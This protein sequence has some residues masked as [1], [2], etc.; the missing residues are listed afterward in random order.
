MAE[1]RTRPVDRLLGGYLLLAAL[2]LLPPERPDAW[3]LLS[4]HLLVAAAL[5]GG[6]LGRIRKRVDRRGAGTAQRTVLALTDWYPLLL[7]PFLYWELPVLSTALH[8][9]QYFDPLVLSWEEAL[10]G[11]QPSTT[12]AYR[13][14]SPFLSELLHLA[15]LSYYP[16]LYFFPAALYVARR[17]EAFYETL[18]AF[19]LGFTINYL[20]FTLFPVQ[21]PRYLF[22]APGGS[23]ADG[24]LYALTHSILEAGSSRGAAFPSAHA[25]VAVIATMQAIR[26]LPGAAPPLAVCTF[27]LSVGAVFGGFHYGVDMIAGVLLGVGIAV[28]APR[29]RRA[30]A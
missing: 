1:P 20:A 30:L 17:L 16:I 21:G 11:G 5:L 18:F 8:G 12:L 28:A 6:A 25:A 26:F 9:G 10:F 29:V 15:Y 4:A 27:G 7:M 22:P 14:S 13:W 24:A 3:L 19:M 23:M 2:F